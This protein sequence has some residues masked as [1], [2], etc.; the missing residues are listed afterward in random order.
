[1][2]HLGHKPLIKIMGKPMIEWA[3]ESLNI[4]NAHYV[5]VIQEKFYKPLDKIFG[6]MV[7]D[8]EVIGIDYITEGAVCTTLLAKRIIDTKEPLLIVNC[9]QYLEWCAPAFLRAVRGYDGAALTYTMD[10]PDGSFCVLDEE[11]YV[12]RTAEK[13]VIS[14]IGSVGIN[15]FGKGSDFVKYAEQRIK[16]NIRTKNEFPVL[17]VYNELIA[18][19]KKVVIHHLREDQK[20]WRIGLQYELDQFL[21]DKG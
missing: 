1:M 5:F 20:V 2:G 17:P 13:E 9:D 18:D 6:R 4:P 3:I 14:T 15:Y 7:K 16:K 8:Y 19:G 21:K 10:R 11:G 12:I